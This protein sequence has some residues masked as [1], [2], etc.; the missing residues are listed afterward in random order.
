MNRT[1]KN[2]LAGMLA[3]SLTVLNGGC[4]TGDQDSKNTKHKRHEKAADKDKGN[5]VRC[6]GH[7]TSKVITENGRSMKVYYLDVTD[8]GP[9]GELKGKSVPLYGGPANMLAGLENKDAMIGGVLINKGSEL[10][11]ISI[12][13]APVHRL[14]PV[15]DAEKSVT[16]DKKL[17]K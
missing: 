7:L 2:I 9:S 14:V 4:A 16:A 1:Q 11:V 17:K 13:P 3:L 15:Q 12:A 10:C 5:A 8:P 6:I